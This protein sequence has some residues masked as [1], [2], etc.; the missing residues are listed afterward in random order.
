[1]EVGKMA[2]FAGE[3]GKPK[4]VEITPAHAKALLGFAGNRSIPSHW[5]HDWFDGDADPIHAR[6]GAL[7]Q[8]RMDGDNLVADLHLS[9]GEHRETALWNAENAPE[10]MMLSAVFNY[11][12]TDPICIP[13][14][15]QAA[16]LVSKGAATTALLAEDITTQN[17]M[18]TDIL[19]MLAEAAKDPAK[20]AALKALIKEIEAGD[21]EDTAAAEMESGAGVTDSD[22][23]KSDDNKPALMRALLRVCRATKRQINELAKSETALLEKA[24][25]QSEASATAL[26]GKGGF[27]KAGA[28]EQNTD[29]Y[30]A[31][32]AEYSKTAPS[33]QV[34]AFRLLKDHPELMPEHEAHTRARMAKLKPAA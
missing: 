9:P 1:M 29:T 4:K 19:T 22:K 34:A 17:N 24:K 23:D 31:K 2:V 3:D 18:D 16:D 28:G 15:F 32:L 6:V 12:K 8:F 25:V 26:L 20:R 5:S 7:K 14:D 33:Q 13:Q 21:D 27:I 10:N 11:A 30:A